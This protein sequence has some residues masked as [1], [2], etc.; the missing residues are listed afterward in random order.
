MRPG[1]E[2]RIQPREDKGI[3]DELIADTLKSSTLNPD[4]E[5]S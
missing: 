3:L 5:F 4:L 1:P 2:I